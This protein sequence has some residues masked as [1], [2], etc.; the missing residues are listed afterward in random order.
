M[1][2]EIKL[3]HKRS[4]YIIQHVNTIILYIPI[5]FSVLIPFTNEK[6]LKKS[7]QMEQVAANLKPKSL[8]S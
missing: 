2:Q 6:L 3:L 7:L 5:I 8:Q 1:S 4:L